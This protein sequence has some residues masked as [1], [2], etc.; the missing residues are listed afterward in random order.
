[1]FI[2]AKPRSVSN[3][4]EAF[5]PI[6]RV[7]SLHQRLVE[8]TNND[9]NAW[10]VYRPVATS[11]SDS[12]DQHID[13]FGNENVSVNNLPGQSES[14]SNISTGPKPIWG[15]LPTSFIGRP[16]TACRLFEDFFL[17]TRSPDPVP[18]E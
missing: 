15:I 3:G 11:A 7:E 18:T 6:H 16:K 4:F 10:S 12:W 14:W 17:Y 1:M 2:N 8:M 5:V 13:D 9:I